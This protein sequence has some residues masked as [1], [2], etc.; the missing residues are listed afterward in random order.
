MYD[1][2][3]RIITEEG[4]DWEAYKKA[5][6]KAINTFKKQYKYRGFVLKEAIE[7]WEQQ[8][9]VEKIVDS[10]TGRTE[11]IPDSNYRLSADN[12][13]YNKL[14]DAQK[15]YY[16]EI[17]TIKGEMGTLLPKWA[18]QQFLPPQIRASTWDL[19]QRAKKEK[20]KASKLASMLLDRMKFW[21]IREDDVEYITSTHYGDYDNTPLRDIPIFYAHSLSNQDELLKDFKEE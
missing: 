9:T 8:N 10:S 7:I 20:W 6:S 4:V 14:S 19:I 17:M 15:E 18:Q 5:R 16:K 21:K 11:R 2:N 3:G 12:N 13:P 1:K